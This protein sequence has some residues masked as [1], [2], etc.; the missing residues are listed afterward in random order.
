M[1]NIR[2]F[3]NI[4]FTRNSR[5]S[6]HSVS[7][8]IPRIYGL[9]HC[10]PNCGY[11]LCVALFIGL[12]PSVSKSATSLQRA[13]VGSWAEIV[14]GGRVLPPS[15]CNPRYFEDKLGRPIYMVGAH[16]WN[17]LVDMGDSIP[18]RKFDYERYLEFLKVHGHNLVR[19]HGLDQPQPGF[20]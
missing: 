8:M 20:L 15:R 6:R 14:S 13:E 1:Y 2:I 9:R 18:I 3:L 10:L 11:W 12:L 17:N 7:T 5:Q 16:T 4:A 19:P